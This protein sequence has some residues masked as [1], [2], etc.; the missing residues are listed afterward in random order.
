[1]PAGARALVPAGGRG[2]RGVPLLR[3]TVAQ[4]PSNRC[5]LVPE[6]QCPLVAVVDGVSLRASV[7]QVPGAQ[8]PHHVWGLRWYNCVL[9]GGSTFMQN[10]DLFEHRLCDIYIYIY[11]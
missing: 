6:P 8:C 5:P 11:C 9:F 4:V 1:M 2:R 3:T 7:A 10:H